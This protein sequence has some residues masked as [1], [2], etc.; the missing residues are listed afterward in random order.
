MM[1]KYGFSN[2]DEKTYQERLICDY[3]SGMMDSYAIS[4][5]EDITGKSFKNI[6]G[7]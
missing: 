2:K 3:I 1:S 6:L 5:Y 7:E 4:I